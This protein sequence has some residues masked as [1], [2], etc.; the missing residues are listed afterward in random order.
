MAPL[1]VTNGLYTRKSARAAAFYALGFRIPGQ[2]AALGSYV[3][4]V[5]WLP[6]AEYGV[7]SLLYAMLP[8]IGTVMSF[9]MENTLGRYQPEYLR[10]G[11]N[12]LANRLSRNI[13]LLRLAT[14]VMF[15]AAILVFW[16]E[17]AP[18]FDIAE[19]R[20]HFMLFALLIITHFQ[21]HI[22]SISLS[23]H[24]LHQYSV[25]LT[26]IFSVLKV[27]G[28]ALAFWLQM[29][30]LRAVILVDLAAYLILFACLK[31]AY[32]SKPDHRKGER[33]ALPPEEKKRLFRYAAYYSFNDVSAL[34]LDTH[35]D[36][37]FL[38][39]MLDRVAVG[40]YSF[41]YRFNEVLGRLSPVYLLETVVQPLFVSLDHR[42]DSQKIQGY[43]SLL[44]TAAFTVRVP[45]LAFTAAYHRAIVE[46]LFGGRFLEYS[47]LLPM[48]ALFA[49]GFVINVP[50]TLVA[51][52]QEKAQFVLASKVF[53]L[54]GMAGSLLLIP[55]MGVLGAV[56]A[57]GTSIL[58]KNLFIWWFV[59][60]LARWHNAGRFAWR[61]VLIWGGFALA[62]LLQQPWVAAQPTLELATGLVIWSAFFLLQIRAAASADE[63]R[64]VGDL[65]SGRER[66]L[67]RL[68]GVA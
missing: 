24:L 58:M 11:E 9:G 2:A 1:H 65:F 63:R 38:A 66:K 56:I 48:T 13:A 54:V 34:T 45:L 68:L 15:L 17:I 23:A 25:G 7:Y 14:S 41:A 64:T 21:C 19:Y 27:V 28:Y 26:A 42:K 53:G 43:F 32:S 59:R 6:E 40:A 31:Y 51:Q 12:R 33:T 22:L 29:F 8:V 10:K 36:N 39:A 16:D 55:V 49:I 30:T 50:V 57:G 60:D 20:D 52:Q 61:A 44:M 62:V 18:F 47:Y 3:V 67:L 5:R 35:K 46:V 37:F 4:L